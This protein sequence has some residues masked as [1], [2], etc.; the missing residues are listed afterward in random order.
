MNNN[1]SDTTEMTV[2]D[3][4]QNTILDV[5]CR[6][7]EILSKVRFDKKK[8]VQCNDTKN[9]NANLM[10]LRLVNGLAII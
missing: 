3:Y 10:R 8:T 5:L 9:R 1:E 7:L 4:L 2:D 6:G